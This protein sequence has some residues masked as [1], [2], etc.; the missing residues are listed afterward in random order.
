MIAPIVIPILDAARC[1]GCGDCVAICPTQC[2]ATLGPLVWLPR[3]RDCVACA[4]CA[5]VCPASAIT[6][7][8]AVGYFTS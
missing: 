6:L 8:G 7:P 3:P 4:A 2:L 5:I 1:I